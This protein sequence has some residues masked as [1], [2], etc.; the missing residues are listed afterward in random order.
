[1]DPAF[2]DIVGEWAEQAAREEAPS[3]S[4]ANEIKRRGTSSLILS[5]RS[6]CGRKSKPIAS[7]RRRPKSSSRRDL[8]DAFGE[9]YVAY[10][11]TTPM[12]IPRPWRRAQAYREESNI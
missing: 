11:R 6:S 5:F 8:V 1:M 3:S 9:R 2:P 10:R 7:G 12:L 4:W